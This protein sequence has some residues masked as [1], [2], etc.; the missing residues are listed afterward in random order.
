MAGSW[1]HI[2]GNG[3]KFIGVRLIDNLGDAYEALEECYGMVHV[4]AS[5]LAA[6]GVGYHDDLVEDARLHYLEGIMWSPGV[7][8]EGEELE[9]EATS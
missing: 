6:A 7:L 2:T 3:G 5:R 4:L 9:D 1:N 8:D